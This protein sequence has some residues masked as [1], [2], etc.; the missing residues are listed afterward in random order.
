MSSARHRFDATAQGEE[1]AISSLMKIFAYVAANFSVID[2]ALVPPYQI[3]ETIHHSLDRHGLKG[4]RASDGQV[5][6]NLA[7]GLQALSAESVPGY[8]NQDDFERATLLAQK[9]AGGMKP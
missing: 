2:D 7:T 1:A 8:Y 6:L 9:I 4:L 3:L 5:I